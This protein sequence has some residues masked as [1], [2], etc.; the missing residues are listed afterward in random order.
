MCS[1]EEG[2]EHLGKELW[3][4]EEQGVD[5]DV[6]ERRYLTGIKGQTENWD[7][8]ERASG[9]KG[10]IVNEQISGEGVWENK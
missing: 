10:C 9:I 2:K 5:K 1:D 4:E 6:M 3:T 8:L 7:G